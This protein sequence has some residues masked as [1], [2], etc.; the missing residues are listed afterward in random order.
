MKLN[1]PHPRLVGLLAITLGVLVFFL[2]GVSIRNIV[3]FMHDSAKGHRE[4]E[5]GIAQLGEIKLTFHFCYSALLH[6]KTNNTQIGN[7]EILPEEVLAVLTNR[8]GSNQT[9]PAWVMPNK[10]FITTE[11]VPRGSDRF[12]CFIL[13]GKPGFE[14]PFV[15]KANG[16]CRYVKIGEVKMNKFTSPKVAANQ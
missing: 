15:L 6:V 5:E 8:N 9:L 4:T 11:K 16:E 2:C 13:L 1:K 3:V 14:E 10:I 12:L 7:Q